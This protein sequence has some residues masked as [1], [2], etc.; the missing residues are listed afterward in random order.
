M[1]GTTSDQELLAR[2]EHLSQP[3]LITGAPES[4][5]AY[6]WIRVAQPLVFCVL[7]CIS[8]FVLLFFFYLAIAL[9]VL[10]LTVWFGL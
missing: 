1:M 5:P 3:L 8:L 9:S 4:T 7:F 10:Q 2:L 6:F